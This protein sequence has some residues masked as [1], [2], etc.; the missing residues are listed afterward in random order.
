MVKKNPTKT[1]KSNLSNQK[2]HPKKK[3]KNHSP[4][5]GSPASKKVSRILVF[6]VKCFGKRRLWLPLS[7]SPQ[8][9]LHSK[10]QPQWPEADWPFGSPS[11]PVKTWR[12][13]PPLKQPTVRPGSI[14]CMLSYVFISFSPHWAHVPLNCRTL[15]DLSFE[16]VNY[17]AIWG[18]F[19]S[20]TII[21]V[22]KGNLVLVCRLYEASQLHNF[23]KK[24]STIPSWFVLDFWTH[25]DLICHCLESKQNMNVDMALPLLQL[26]ISL[27][28]RNL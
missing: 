18:A 21:D 12:R 16:S 7:S 2:K 28:E 6:W 25:E 24:D 17:W 3:H 10:P 15:H 9:W 22:D 26:R 20:K 14:P 4:N 5:L 23:F 1:S 13:F 19:K 8:P 27:S 11:S